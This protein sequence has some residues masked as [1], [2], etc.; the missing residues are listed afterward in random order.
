MKL[1]F[2][3]KLHAYSNTTLHQVQRDSLADVTKVTV[4]KNN[5]KE[6]KITEFLEFI[7]NPYCYNCGEVLVGVAFAD[8][9]DTLEVLITNLIARYR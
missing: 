6:K 1:L 2:T 7:E 9:N 5:A 3:N 4:N 8:T